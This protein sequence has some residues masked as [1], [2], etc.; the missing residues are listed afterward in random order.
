[1]D[2]NHEEDYAFSRNFLSSSS[3]I[4]NTVSTRNDAF[5]GQ[6]DEVLLTS[7]F[8]WR[9]AAAMLKEKRSNQNVLFNIINSEPIEFGSTGLPTS[10]N[11][12]QCIRESAW[13]VPAEV[14]NIVRNSFFVKTVREDSDCSN[15]SQL[16]DM[17]VGGYRLSEYL[18]EGQ[19]ITEEISGYVLKDLVGEALAEM[20][21]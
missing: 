19:E 18:L 21:D 14:L 7:Y 2:N 12:N 8:Y 13:V 6:F 3:E 10:K 15:I 17:M 16:L 9:E 4:N 20:N 5:R 1:M 11:V